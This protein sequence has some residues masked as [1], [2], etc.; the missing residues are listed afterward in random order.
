MSSYKD[1][2]IYRLAY[3]LAVKIQSDSLKLLHFETNYQGSQIRQSS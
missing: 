3:S 1:L 2:E